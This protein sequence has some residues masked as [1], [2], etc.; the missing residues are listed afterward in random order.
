MFEVE[1]VY[2]VT[3]SVKI[4]NA[5]GTGSRNCKCDSWLDR[6]QYFSGEKALE[7]CV[8]NCTGKAEIGALVIRPLAKNKDYIN[9]PYIVPM[10]KDHH[11]TRGVGVEFRTKENTTFVW[12]NVGKI[13]GY[14]SRFIGKDKPVLNLDKILK[15]EIVMNIIN[16]TVILL[17]LAVTLA[18]CTGK[19][20][21]APVKMIC[22]AGPG[23]CSTNT[24]ASTLLARHETIATL[25]EIKEH[26]CMGRTSACPDNCGHSGKVAVFE[27]N[28]YLKHQQFDKWGSGKQ[29]RFFIQLTGFKE[30]SSSKIDLATIDKVKELNAGDKVYLS[31]DHCRIKTASASRGERKV[32]KL[33]KF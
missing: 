23:P 24:D 33:C 3:K 17:L 20:Q 10:C 15:W 11:S 16:P 1:V 13:C 4:M 18:S 27:V 19:K 28:E 26:K 6:W 31:W 32:T 2:S 29:N 14:K 12:A 5:R 21:S 8:E 30:R 25:K 7:C 9:R 22:P